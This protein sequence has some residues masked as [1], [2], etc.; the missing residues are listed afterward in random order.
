MAVEE[1]ELRPTI[2]RAWL[3]SAAAR[4]PIEHAYA[5]W[6]LLHHPDRI[7][8]VS[9]V[10][11]GEPLG[12]LLLWLG[13]PAAPVV[14]WIGTD[15]RLG[16]LAGRLPPRPLVAIVP[17]EFA[18]RV[19]EARGPVRSFPLLSMIAAE[20]A[21]Q[22]RGETAIRRL[23]RDD[24]AD[25][26]RWA[27]RQTDSVV[28]EYATFDPEA[29]LAWGAFEDGRIVGVAR[30]AVRLPH[31][32]ILGGVYVEPAARGEGW[33]RALVETALTAAIATGASLALYVREDRTP[34]RS[35]YASLGF[36]TVGRRL[37]MDAGSG[38][39]P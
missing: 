3:E 28:A 27:S 36:R 22:A 35:L 14:H 13:H 15:P 2:D 38:L 37:W 5:L 17:E 21:P 10:V 7:R 23:R 6:D 29:E 25:L 20:S 30:A 12:Y 11:D 18:Y 34:A 32:W 24:R 31:V 1:V 9:A 33:G 8:I 16:E 19:S 26:S 39:T 4:D